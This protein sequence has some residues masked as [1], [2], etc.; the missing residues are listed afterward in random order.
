MHILGI[1]NVLAVVTVTVFYVLPHMPHWV[2]VGFW[3]TLTVWQ[4]AEGDAL[5]AAINAGI[6]VGEWHKP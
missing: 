6:T 4:I 2:R 1:L 5:F 3:L